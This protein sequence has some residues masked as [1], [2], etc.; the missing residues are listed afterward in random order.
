[1]TIDTARITV[2]S[3][4]TVG[5]DFGKAQLAPDVERQ[6]RLGAGQEEGDDE[7]VERDQEGQHEGRGD[8]RRG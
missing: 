4:I 3:A 5:S 7:L 6:R 2:P 8:G 1:M